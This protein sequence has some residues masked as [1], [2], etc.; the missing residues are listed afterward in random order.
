MFIPN[1]SSG[2]EYNP[3]TLSE[4]ILYLLEKLKK[5]WKNELESIVYVICISNFRTCLRN[6]EF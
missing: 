5:L 4:Q 2:I 3:T 1:T 6:G